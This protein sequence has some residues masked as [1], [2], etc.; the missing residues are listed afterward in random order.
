MIVSEAVNGATPDAAWDLLSTRRREMWVALE[1]FWDHQLDRIKESAERKA[2]ERELGQ[3]T[4][5]ERG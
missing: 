2:K 1:P 3:D 5:T 4:F